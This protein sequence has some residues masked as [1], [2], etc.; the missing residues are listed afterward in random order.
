MS[1]TVSAGTPSHFAFYPERSVPK[2]GYMAVCAAL[3]SL[4][5][6]HDTKQALFRRSLPCLVTSHL[7]KAK[8][9]AKRGHGQVGALVEPAVISGP[10]QLCDP[11]HYT[12]GSY[13]RWAAPLYFGT[14]RKH[15]NHTAWPSSGQRWN[16]SAELTMPT[17]SPEHLPDRNPDQAQRARHD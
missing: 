3:R 10:H 1:W 15:L 7:P 14:Q 5:R 6:R 13:L 16:L 12:N 11:S 8:H 17:E 2:C 4:G 9:N